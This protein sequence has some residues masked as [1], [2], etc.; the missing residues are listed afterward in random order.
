[1][2]RFIKNKFFILAVVLM[3]IL[4][5]VP[6][7]LNLAGKGGYVRSA[8]NILMTPAQKAFNYV[9]DAIDG[10]T[11]YFTKFDD[12]VKENAHLKEEIAALNNRLYQAEKTEELN[13]WLTA[14]L[15]MKRSHTD[16]TFA[17]AVITGRES[18]NHM[19]VCTIDRGTAH[20]IAEGMPV[21]TPDGVLGYIDEAGLTWAKVRTLIEFSTSIGACIERTGELGLVEGNFSLAADGICRITY[22]AA[23]SDVRVGD[24]VVTSGTGG[25][26]PRDLVIGY[27]T[28]VIPDEYSRTLTATIRPA[29]TLTDLDRVMIITSY[30]T[31]TE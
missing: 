12:M 11:S 18:A 3:L 21:V 25:I 5:V 10:F 14:F 8:V 26:Y 2:K 4:T 1:M 27:V 28:E 15:E 19:T 23:D 16:F 6:T 24:R 13:Q 17:E 31:V 7:V 30:E 20:G 9:T 29:A 22:L